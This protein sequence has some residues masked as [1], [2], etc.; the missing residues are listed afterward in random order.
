M[1]IE[2]RYMCMHGQKKGLLLGIKVLKREEITDK[3]FKYLRS[4]DA[5]ATFNLEEGCDSFIELIFFGEQNIPFAILEP[6][7]SDIYDFAVNNKHKVISF[8]IINEPKPFGLGMYK[9][10]Q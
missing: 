9:G 6:Y 8:K 10:Q 5:C 7:K 4:L 1:Y 2:H 3:Q